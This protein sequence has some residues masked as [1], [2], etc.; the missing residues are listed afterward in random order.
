M[1]NRNEDKHYWN[2]KGADLTK[3]E[4]KIVALTL[5]FGWGGAILAYILPFEKSKAVGF[6]IASLFALI[7]YVVGRRRVK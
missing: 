5:I 4:T 3:R 6:G 1:L 2:F 7:G